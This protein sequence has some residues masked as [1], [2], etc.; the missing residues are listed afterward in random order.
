MFGQ[1]KKTNN[2]CCGFLVRH[3]LRERSF[4]GK[5][6]RRTIVGGMLRNRFLIAFCKNAIKP[7]IPRIWA[8]FLDSLTFKRD[9]CEFGVRPLSWA[10]EEVKTTVEIATAH[11]N[12][13]AIFIERGQRSRNDV[14]FFRGYFAARNGFPDAK[15][16]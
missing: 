9:S 3:L 16:I 1:F 6:R 2:K 15:C 5:E 10:P 11:A 14:K 4:V 7:Y 12:T 13:I 8:N